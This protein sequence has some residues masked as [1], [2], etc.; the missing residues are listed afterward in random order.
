MSIRHM[1]NARLKTQLPLAPNHA[2]NP[3]AMLAVLGGTVGMALGF[4]CL[5]LT[6]VFM[7]PLEA[8][9]GWSRA[10]VSLGYGIAAAG[11]NDCQTATNSC[12]GMTTADNLPD[13]WIYVPTGTCEKI[14]GGSLEPT[15]G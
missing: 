14:A 3:H 13:A 8:A 11:K 4:G 9:F 7:Q 15:E 10:E 6:S 1:S 2:R 5:A 12:A